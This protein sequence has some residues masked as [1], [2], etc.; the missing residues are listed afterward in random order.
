M[1]NR[2]L[3]SGYYGFENLGDDLILEVMVQQLKALGYEPVVLSENPSLTS[4]TYDVKSLLR[5]NIPRIWDEMKEITAFIS[6]GGGLFQDATGLGSPIYYGGLI[7]MAHRRKIPIAFFAQGIGP[8]QTKIGRWMTKRT[9]LQS[10][11]VVVR[12]VKSQALAQQL[13]GKKVKLMADPVW[14]WQPKAALESNGQKRLGISLR[15]WPQLHDQA[16]QHL[17]NCIAQWPKI[18]ETGLNLIDCQAGADILPLAKL[19]KLL[20]EKQIAC[21]WFMGDNCV[22]GIAQTSVLLAMRY[23]AILVAA[24]LNV[25][26]VALAYDPKVKLLAAQLRINSFQVGNI[27]SLTLDALL[28]AVSDANQDVI[29]DLQKFAQKGFSYLK[30]WL[31]AKGATAQGTDSPG[32]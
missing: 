23:H 25:P 30:A 27:V 32:V 18:Q 6:G 28:D 26:V 13:A 8:L 2:I 22:Q 11:L 9:L 3:L 31:T 1:S 5:T 21:Y 15:Q 24:K 17:A 29:V 12:D 16:I 7:E 10:D 4:S 14:N 20:K 19:E